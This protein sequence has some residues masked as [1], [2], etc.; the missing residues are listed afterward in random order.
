MKIARQIR[1]QKLQNKNRMVGKTFSTLEAHQR[2]KNPWLGSAWFEEGM[3]EKREQFVKEWH[4]ET[5]RLLKINPNLEI[6]L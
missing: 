5:E 1:I 4:K 2:R 6:V 3:E